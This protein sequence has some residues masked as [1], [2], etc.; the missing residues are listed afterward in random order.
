M[1]FYWGMFFWC[2]YKSSALWRFA[3]QRGKV[4]ILGWWLYS[5]SASVLGEWWYQMLLYRQNIYNEFGNYGV[6]PIQ[7]MPIQRYSLV[8]LCQLFVCWLWSYVYV[9]SFL[10]SHFVSWNILQ[11]ADGVMTRFRHIVGEDFQGVAQGDIVPRRRARSWGEE[12]AQALE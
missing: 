11:F 7:L 8:V 2:M 12:V 10:A 5:T 3:H 1:Y 6:C 9:D 4:A